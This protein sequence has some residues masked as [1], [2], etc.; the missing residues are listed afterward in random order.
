VTAFLLPLIASLLVT[1]G[2]GASMRSPVVPAVAPTDQGIAAYREVLFLYDPGARY[3]S[4]ALRFPAGSVH[5]P[6]G[7]EGTAFL[8]GQTIAQASNHRLLGH[9]SRVE[10]DVTADALSVI[11]IA[12]PDRLAPALREL[13]EVLFSTSLVIGDVDPIRNEVLQALRF[14]EGSPGRSFDQQ[15]AYLLLGSTSPAARPR[16]GSLGTLPGIGVPEL[17]NFR[18]E[19]LAREVA[20]VVVTGPLQESEVAA[21][22]RGNVRAVTM[23]RRGEMVE[24]SPSVD[25]PLPGAAG[26]AT[27]VGPGL[28]SPAPVFRLNPGGLDPLRVPTQPGLA[29]AWDAPDR[30][31]LDRQI[32]ATWIAVAFPFPEGT[33]DFLLQFLSHLV[34]ENV[35]R[36][37]PDPGLYEVDV[38]VEQVR[39]TPVVVI[40]ASVDPFRA[41]E[42]EAR[43]VGS[44]ETLAQSPPEGSFFELTR[45]R[46][47]S[48]LLLQLATPESLVR[49]IQ[50]HQARGEL[51]VPDP[52]L[53]MWRLDRSAVAEAAAAAG[54]PRTL[55]YGP[56]GLG[57]R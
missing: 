2:D 11:L 10:V 36:T 48:R 34:R 15:R 52:E 30:S 19:H 42:W 23:G 43:L 6:V 57:S 17:S 9:Q 3:V 26:E 31:V 56:Q 14:E 16:R 46:F 21:A 4:V 22:F 55:I 40:S 35:D 45:R 25:E 50:L 8:L 13:E 7:G 18:S 12:P 41:A 20:D 51:P 5:D 24:P 1:S 44:L 39:G 37:P 27:G 29:R 53:A 28:L 49:W 54:P 33:S 32:T 47:R 38:A